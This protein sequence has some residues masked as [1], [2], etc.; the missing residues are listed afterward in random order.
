MSISYNPLSF[1]QKY[2]KKINRIGI[3][4]FNPLPPPDWFKITW[5]HNF[6]QISLKRI[7]IYV[8]QNLGVSNKFRKDNTYICKISY[9]V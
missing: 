9:I 5:M 4:A 1:T 2:E 8:L 6:E 3:G 7:P